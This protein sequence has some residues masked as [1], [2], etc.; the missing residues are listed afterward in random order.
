ME[1]E[2]SGY[3]MMYEVLLSQGKPL[4]RVQE[5]E[6]SV[7]AIVERRILNRE[8]IKIMQTAFQNFELK[9]KQII[10]L[11]LIAQNE[12]MTA[13]QLL[14]ALNIKDGDALRAVSM[15]DSAR[16]LMQVW[17][18]SLKASKMVSSGRSM[19]AFRQRNRN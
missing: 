8:T 6:D 9:Q 11:G 4:P 5:G 12:S 15:S 1:R 3:D 7:T 19:W 10:C 16:T 17:Y 18:A 14:S 2:G 13:S